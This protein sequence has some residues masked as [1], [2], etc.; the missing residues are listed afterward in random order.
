MLVNFVKMHGLGNDFVV[1][2]L[3]T[4]NV[5]LNNDHIK[6]IADR[7]FGIGCDQVILLEPP[8]S[9]DRDFYY[10]IYNPDG[11]EAEQCGNGARCAA[12][13]FYDAGFIKSGRTTLTADCLAGPQTFQLESND[14]IT[15]NMGAPIFELSK[16]PMNLDHSLLTHSDATATLS[17]IRSNPSSPLLYSCKV[18]GQ[19]ISFFPVSM[20]NPHIVLQVQSLESTAISTLGPLLEKHPQFPNG[21]NVGFMQVIDAHHIVLRVFERRAG[22]T[23]ACG[24]GA[25][26]AVVAGIRQGVLIS[27]VT[28]TFSNGTLT[29]HW[30]GDLNDVLMSGPTVSVFFGRFRL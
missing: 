3:I 25:S 2:D 7:R 23:L 29:V 9:G 16:I 21:V 26:A 13:F 14:N 8:I 12:R 4:Q 17:P 15:V 10:R 18:A 24:S 20:G 11:S 6:K 19:D 5:R 22:E 27:P 28:V 1:I 30:E